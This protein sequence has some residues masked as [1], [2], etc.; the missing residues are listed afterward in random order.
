MKSSYDA[1]NLPPA[2]TTLQHSTGPENPPRSNQHSAE[3]TNQVLLKIL[4]LKTNRTAT[5][6]A[7]SQP[8]SSLE[9]NSRPNEAKEAVDPDNETVVLPPNEQGV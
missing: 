1:H 3:W 8:L 5:E 6:Q 7:L 9:N 4:K 2:L